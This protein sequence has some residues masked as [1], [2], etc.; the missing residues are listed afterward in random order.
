MAAIQMRQKFGWDK[1]ADAF[2]DIIARN[3]PEV[4]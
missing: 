2:I 1:A 4:A 3:Y